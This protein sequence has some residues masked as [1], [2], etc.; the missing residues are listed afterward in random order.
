LEEKNERRPAVQ[1][2]QNKN[3]ICDHTG[4]VQFKSKARHVKERASQCKE[5]WGTQHER[6]D[7]RAKTPQGDDD[8]DWNPFLMGRFKLR[9]IPENR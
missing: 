8:E 3:L 5:Q 1:R 7:K 2:C 6:K 9:F 4:K